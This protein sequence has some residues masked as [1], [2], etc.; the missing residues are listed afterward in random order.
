VAA[1]GLGTVGP[2]Y[3]TLG[4]VV[5]AGAA[6]LALNRAERS[7]NSRTGLPRAVAAVTSGLILMVMFHSA[8]NQLL[9]IAASVGT[10][11]TVV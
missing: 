4:S 7:L 6:G 5:L 2:W 9:L 10:L 3:I 8:D 11:F 1:L